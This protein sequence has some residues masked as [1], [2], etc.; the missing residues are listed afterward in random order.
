ME[1]FKTYLIVYLNS[2]TGVCMFAFI[3]LMCI[4]ILNY[5]L[6]YYCNDIGSVLSRLVNNR[7][8]VATNVLVNLQYFVV[9]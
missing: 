8:I 6:N 2:C 4:Y 5:I 7:N 3:D 1:R 9:D